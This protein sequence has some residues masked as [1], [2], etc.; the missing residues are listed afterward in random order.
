M[1]KAIRLI[2]SLTLAPFIVLAQQIGAPTNLLAELDSTNK[3]INLSW[4]ASVD[5]VAG[6][7]LLVKKT[8]SKHFLLWGKAGLISETNY[9]FQVTEK[10]GVT[11]S[12][13]VCAVQNFP[14]VIRGEYSNTIIVEVPSSYI[15]MVKLNDPRVR[16]NE[17]EVTWEY[18]FKV[19]DLK[20]F[21]LVID[22]K[23]ISLPDSTRR[24][25]LTDLQE[26]KYVIQIIAYSETGLKSKLSVKKFITIK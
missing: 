7:N 4:D 10:M 22:N 16:R 2:F 14:E 26:G 23:E 15:P 9:T 17:V 21:I 18:D 20:G 19:Q 5:K 24:Y 3:V 8:D 6:Y 12:F 11:Y 1:M 13:K 25:K